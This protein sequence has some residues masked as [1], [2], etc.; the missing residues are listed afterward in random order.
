MELVSVVIPTYGCRGRLKE[1]ID[2][3]LNQSYKPIEVI[4]VDD[5]SPGSDNRLKTEEVLSSF[6]STPEVNYIKHPEN[7]NGAAARNTGIKAAKGE[8][9]AFLDDDDCFS[10][11]KIEEQHHY[12]K[13]H[14]EFD[15]V[16]CLAVKRGQNYS[17]TAYEGRP[18][19]EMLLM[20]TCMYTPC[21][22]FRRKPLL[23][24]NGFDESLRR[25]QDY[26]LLLRF[27]GNG[28]SIGCLK[29]ELTEIGTNA[30]E[31]EIY[32]DKLEALKDY[33]FSKFGKYIDEIDIQEPGFRNE[34][35]AKH[36][37]TVFLKHLKKKDLKR[38]FKTFVK[39]FR[40]SPKVFINVING[41]IKAHLK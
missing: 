24:I 31:N 5:N 39:Y 40:L 8:F 21:L 14:P 35:Y 16:Y 30:G 26:D 13:E 3:A 4:V 19:K 29:K 2:S 18:I 11:T 22:M 15:A 32:G 34:V 10:P 27:F 33:F 23:S 25:H 17:P 36:Y 7:R 9:I 41:S 37:A 38:A 1:S 6:A 28:F 20:Q 12:L